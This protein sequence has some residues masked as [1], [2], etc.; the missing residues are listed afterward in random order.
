MSCIVRAVLMTGAVALCLGCDLNNQ[1]HGEDL[2][3]SFSS[4]HPLKKFV[5][6]PPQ[7]SQKYMHVVVLRIVSST[8]WL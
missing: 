8:A 7:P 1:G 2:Y 3:A 6:D 4:Q 5:P